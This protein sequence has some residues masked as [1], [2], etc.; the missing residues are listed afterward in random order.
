MAMSQYW[1]YHMFDSGIK[2]RNKFHQKGQK[3]VCSIALKSQS[4]IVS[5]GYA[6][7]F[8]DIEPATR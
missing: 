6:T 7:G 5:D 4:E 3:I 8:Y 2:T 1:Q